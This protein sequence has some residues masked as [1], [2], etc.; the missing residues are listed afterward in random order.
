MISYDYTIIKVEVGNE[1]HWGRIC[2]NFKLV[3]LLFSSGLFHNAVN[4]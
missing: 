3:G 1:N 4:I 2:V